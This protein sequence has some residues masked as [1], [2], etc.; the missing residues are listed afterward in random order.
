MFSREHRSGIFLL[1]L[2]I[3]LFQGF[4]FFYDF[5]SNQ[6]SEPSSE[7]MAWLSM[8]HEIDSIKYLNDSLKN[9]IKPF[10]PNF[11]S[12]YKGS[13][14][15][16][17]VAEIDRLLKYRAENKY[18]NSAEEFQQVTQVSDE[19]LNK[20]APHFKFPDWASK[21]YTSNKEY[22]N[23]FKF[24]KFSEK[25]NNIKS[26][27]NIATKEELMEVFGIG[28]KISD[29]ILAER[30]KFGGFV[31]LEQL[32]FIWGVSPEAYEDIQKRFFVEPN[33]NIKKID[34]N[35]LSMKELAK[36]PYFNYYLAKSI[37]TYRSMNGDFKNIEDL[38]KIKDFPVEKI[39][40]IALYL[41]F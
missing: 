32:S 27:V 28:D 30:T 39:K 36:F 31:S 40:I 26:D 15:G 16:M 2:I 10:N 24:N 6:S 13:V 4:Y 23:N 12:D 37:V 18:V 34:I 21:K 41:E 35:N 33:P 22:P 17:S 8:Q 11:I 19:L 29:I 1:I 3:I 25:K 5:S 7:E 14:L 20:L 38:T 9:Q